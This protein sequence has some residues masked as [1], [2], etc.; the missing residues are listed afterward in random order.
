MADFE[1]VEIFESIN[2]EG[3]F[4]GELSNFVRLKGCNLRCTY[5]DTAWAY[6]ADAPRTVMTEE[7]ICC[8]LYTSDAADE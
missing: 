1:V 8:L 5:C 6:E 4:A 3:R 2:G 7:E